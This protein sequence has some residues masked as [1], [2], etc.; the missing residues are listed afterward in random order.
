[1]LSGSVTATLIGYLLLMHV[2]EF[3][4]LLIEICIEQRFVLRKNE[5]VIQLYSRV[6]YDMGLCCVQQIDKILIKLC[7]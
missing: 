6:Q 7:S 1:M 4:R 2:K 3:G 5:V